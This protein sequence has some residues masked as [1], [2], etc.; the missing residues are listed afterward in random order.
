MKM[1]RSYCYDTR[2]QQIVILTIICQLAKLFHLTK[3]LIRLCHH[4]ASPLPLPHN[5]A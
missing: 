4:K 1:N 2:I 3:K 5:Y